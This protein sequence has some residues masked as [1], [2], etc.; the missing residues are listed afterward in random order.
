MVLA[1]RLILQPKEKDQG[2]LPEAIVR[3]LVGSR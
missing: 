2:T 1:H 3:Q